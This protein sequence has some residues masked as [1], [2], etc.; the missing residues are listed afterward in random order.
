MRSVLLWGA[1]LGSLNAF[2][3]SA[4]RQ[5]RLVLDKTKLKNLMDA[6]DLPSDSGDMSFVEVDSESKKNTAS[7]EDV[8]NGNYE[9]QCKT[10]CDFKK[11]GSAYSVDMDSP[12]GSVSEGSTG[13]SESPQADSESAMPSAS[14]VAKK[15]QRLQHIRSILKS[16]PDNAAL[17]TRETELQ[18]EISGMLQQ[19]LGRV[20][21]ATK[22][23]SE[24]MRLEK[25]IAMCK[26]KLTQLLKTLQTNTSPAL[27]DEL[28]QLQKLTTNLEQ[29]NADADSLVAAGLDAQIAALQQRL[30]ELQGEKKEKP[31][32]DEDLE[33]AIQQVQAAIRQKTDNSFIP[34]KEC[35]RVCSNP[36]APIR[37][38]GDL[39]QCVKM[40]V[41]IMKKVVHHVSKNLVKND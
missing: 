14:E 26:V 11:K 10:T 30:S 29:A 17:R 20:G 12:I 40:C 36:S 41:R 37:A 13:S 9:L 25:A 35:Y 32:G 39:L 38:G 4:S 21:V 18:L 2:A 6:F 34:V 31:E 8:A 33:G 24:P 23:K 22:F 3:N 16:S 28:S 5:T 19:M 15:Q 7:P 1:L 27:R